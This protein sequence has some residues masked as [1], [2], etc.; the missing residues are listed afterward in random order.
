MA[1]EKQLGQQDN[2]ICVGDHFKTAVL[3]KDF[4][5]VPSIK[6]APNKCLSKVFLLEDWEGIWYWKKKVN[7]V[8]MSSQSLTAW[9]WDILKLEKKFLLKYHSFS[10]KET[11]YV[12]KNFLFQVLYNDTHFQLCTNF[13]PIGVQ[14]IVLLTQSSTT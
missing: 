7:R 12:F 11:Q 9:N 4:Y 6:Q 10:I 13:V 5:S 3:E 2:Q 1:K 8:H 14:G